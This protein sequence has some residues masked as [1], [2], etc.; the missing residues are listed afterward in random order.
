LSAEIIESSEQLTPFSTLTGT[1]LFITTWNTRDLS[2]GSTDEYT[3][4][5]PTYQAEY[6]GQIDWG[7]A[8]A[9]ETFNGTA[10]ILQ[11]TYTLP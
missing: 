11:H 10:P 5:I 8:S 1:D 9:V 4:K 3:I 2:T 7:D 6:S